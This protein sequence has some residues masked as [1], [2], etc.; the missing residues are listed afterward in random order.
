MRQPSVWLAPVEGEE[1]VTHGVYA[2]VRHPF[3][4]GLL[5]AALGLAFWTR[6]P[7]RLTIVGIL[8]AFL[9]KVVELEERYL[10]DAF[11]GYWEYTERVGYRLIPGLF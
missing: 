2:S 6:S 8:F 7:A 5:L 1:L 11:L 10:R 9:I 4:S 3:Y